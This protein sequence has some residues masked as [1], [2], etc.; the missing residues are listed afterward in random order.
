VEEAKRLV[1]HWLNRYDWR[2]H[3]AQLNLLTQFTLPI[4][5]DD[6]GP[7]EIHFVHQTSPH[8]NAIPL[9]FIHG[10]PGHF[11]EVSKILPLLTNPEQPETTTAFHVVAP[12][13]PGFAF[14]SNPTKKGF[15]IHK[16]AETFNKLMVSLGY[17]EYVAQGGDWGSSISRMLG[18]LYP[19]NCKAVH[20]NL[21]KGVGPPV[22]YKNPWVWIK[23]HSQ[24]VHYTREEEVM[25]A[26][27]R[28]FAD[29]ESG[30]RVDTL[31]RLGD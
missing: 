27:G 22:W 31:S 30:Y 10:W 7:L 4:N 8:P 26:R 13:I 28:W 24:L 11:N 23:M 18:V 6:F 21:Q 14:S 15:N 20:V 9:I 3:E 29:Y 16:I 17:H 19:Q 25:M 2:I 1:D 5:V 12:S